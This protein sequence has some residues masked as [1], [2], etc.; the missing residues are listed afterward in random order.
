MIFLFSICRF[1]SYLFLKKKW[2]DWQFL[3]GCLLLGIVKDGWRSRWVI[4]DWKRSEGKAG[5]FKH[6]AGKWH[7]DP[8][9][10]GTKSQTFGLLIEAIFRI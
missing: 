2:F 5:Y 6:T 9:D 8:D 4:S 3:L 1:L 7:G 10:K